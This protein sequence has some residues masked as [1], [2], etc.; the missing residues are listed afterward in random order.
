M[1]RGAGH[2]CFWGAGGRPQAWGE[3]GQEVDHRHGGQET[4]HRLGGRPVA[5]R[6]PYLAQVQ[7][8]YESHL[9]APASW[10]AHDYMNTADLGVSGL[11]FFTF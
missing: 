3:G 6:K 11:L 8:Q 1:R 4:D 9:T 5:T 10:L 2:G 7:A